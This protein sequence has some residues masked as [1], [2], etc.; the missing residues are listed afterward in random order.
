[1]IF[2]LSNPTERSE[3]TPADL[4]KWT[5]EKAVIGTGSPFE[6][7]TKQGKPFRV[8]QTNNC[9]IF[10][11]MGLGI[12]AVKA[13]RITDTMFMVAA[14]ALAECSPAKSNHEAN[15]LPALTDIREVSLRVALAVAKEA[16]DS[17]F[18]DFN[19]KQDLEKYIR[20]MMW[21]PEYLPYKKF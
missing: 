7:I 19:P 3:A 4:M 5:N 8:D 6:D 20:G 15:L 9:Y 2:P 11:G 17:G 10:P 18:A 16:I 14:K 1:M 12:I 21:T 13:T